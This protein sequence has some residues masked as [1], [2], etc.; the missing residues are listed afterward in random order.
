[1][2]VAVTLGMNVAVVDDFDWGFT[3]EDEIMEW[4][5]DDGL[6]PTIPCE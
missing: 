5:F 6:K 1:M 3:T 4:L 2:K